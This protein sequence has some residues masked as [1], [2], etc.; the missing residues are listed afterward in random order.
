[1]GS[2]AK[3][4]PN[5]PEATL[6]FASAAA[7]ARASTPSPVTKT[8]RRAAPPERLP[9]RETDN[10]LLRIQQGDKDALAALF[11]QYS[12]LV[13]SIGHRVL[14]NVHDAEDLVQEV[15]L[16][17]WTKSS[18]FDPD[19]GAGRSWL[20]RVIYHRA[21]NRRRYLMRRA[22]PS[23]AGGDG[24][25][26]DRGHSAGKLANLESR[27]KHLGEMF[28]WHSFLEPAF[29]QLS[30][31][32]RKTLSLFFYEGY[33]LTEVSK[34]LGEP[35]YNVRAYYYRGLKRLARYISGTCND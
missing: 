34:E 15:F 5:P 20:V 27:E 31:N 16:F 35:L 28:Y 25:E 24:S 26:D 22:S 8:D 32:Q 4:L 13:F 1:M 14:R 23:D 12:R 10:L 29:G 9:D 11:D 2:D 7:P 30:E 21:F 33:T 17:I 3:G 19:Q 18:L 6:L